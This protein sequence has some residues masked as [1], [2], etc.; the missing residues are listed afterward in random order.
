M[1]TII[2]IASCFLFFSLIINFA[3]AQ[4]FQ[5]NSLYANLNVGLARAEDEIPTVNPTSTSQ[6][7]S[8]FEG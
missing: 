6:W 8:L 7:D 5:K 4:V 3:E 2:K 1:K